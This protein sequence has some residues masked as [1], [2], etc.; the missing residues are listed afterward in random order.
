MADIKARITLTGRE[1]VRT[2]YRPAHNIN[3]YFTTGVH[4][5]ECEELKKGESCIGDIT[6]ITPEAYPHTLEVGMTILF[7]EGRRVVGFAE[8]L[9]IYNDALRLDEN[10]DGYVCKYCRK[11]F[12]GWGNNPA[13]FGLHYSDR[14]IYGIEECCNRCNAL[15]TLT[16]RHI[17][18]VIA[19]DYS[20]AQLDKL[21][22]HV[23]F[24]CQNL[25]E[26]N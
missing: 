6:F 9:E 11:K 13:D 12:K 1:L 17:H 20:P 15:V 3:G 4:E 19:S 16:N 10:D 5:Y 21:R 22:E 26:Q 24:V 25:K 7:Y 14:D 8:V 2:N 18:D 23:L